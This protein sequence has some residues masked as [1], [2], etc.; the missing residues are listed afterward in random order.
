MN[1]FEISAR[2]IQRITTNVKEG[3]TPVTFTPPTGDPVVINCV[4]ILHNLKVDDIGRTVS[5]LTARV[6]V[7]TLELARLNYTYRNSSDQVALTGHTVS[8]VD[9]SGVT[10]VFVVQD[11]M[12][13]ESNG[14]IV[15]NLSK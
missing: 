11:E 12:A 1:L 4:A 5:G 8:W 6:T 3:S 7:S 14:I 2:D 13:G 15:L 10:R 9:P